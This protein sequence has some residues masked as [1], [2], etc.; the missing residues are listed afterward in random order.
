MLLKISLCLSPLCFCLQ[1]GEGLQKSMS[2][3]Y[4]K[5]DGK[6]PESQ[7]VDLLQSEVSFVFLC[8]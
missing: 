7:A 4:E 6:N 8:I 2:D 3:V 1:I 5:Y